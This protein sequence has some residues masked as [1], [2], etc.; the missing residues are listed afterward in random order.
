MLNGKTNTK[1]NVRCS[2]TYRQKFL[3]LNK[4]ENSRTVVI[5]STSERK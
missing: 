4:Q 1:K 5:D 2:L 3:K